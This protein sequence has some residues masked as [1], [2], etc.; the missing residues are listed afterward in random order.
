V[1]AA[2]V[3]EPLTVLA[4]ALPEHVRHQVE[5]PRL[6]F[7]EVGSNSDFLVP[8]AGL[9]PALPAPEAGALSSELR[10]HG[11]GGLAPW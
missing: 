4:K 10:G 5:G 1:V 9:E 8:P 3:K 11:G 7:L 2:S 6:A